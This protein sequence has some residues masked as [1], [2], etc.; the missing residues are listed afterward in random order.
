[1]TRLESKLHKVTVDPQKTW[2]QSIAS[3][4]KSNLLSQSEK[5][6]LQVFPPETNETMLKQSFSNLRQQFASSG[7]KLQPRGQRQNP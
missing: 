7:R 5:E 4:K 6:P 3:D 1:M 2:N